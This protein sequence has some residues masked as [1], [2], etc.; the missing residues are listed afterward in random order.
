MFRLEIAHV[1]LLDD[2]LAEQHGLERQTRAKAQGHARS[3]GIFCSQAVQD[4]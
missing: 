4:E 2:S 3:W 1:Q